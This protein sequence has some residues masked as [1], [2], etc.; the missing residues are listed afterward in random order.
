MF[1]LENVIAFFEKKSL[2]P[3]LEGLPGSDP[4]T[5]LQIELERNDNPDQQNP[6]KS[7]AFV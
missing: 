4:S 6:L 3:Y 5:G 1:T 7:T 2:N